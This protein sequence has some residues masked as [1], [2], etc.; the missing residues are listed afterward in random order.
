[1]PIVLIFSYVNIIKGQ[2]VKD[3]LRVQLQNKH[4]TDIYTKRTAAE[5]RELPEATLITH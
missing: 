4:H 5:C 3:L 2:S 1:M